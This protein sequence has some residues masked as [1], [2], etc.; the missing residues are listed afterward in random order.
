MLKLLQNSCDESSPE[1]VVMG[2]LSNPIGLLQKR[3]QPVS[4]LEEAGTMPARV[5]TRCAASLVSKFPPLSLVRR[6]QG[7]RSAKR[8]SQSL[9]QSIE[10]VHQARTSFFESLTD[11]S[12]IAWI[13]PDA[14]APFVPFAALQRSPHAVDC[15]GKT[16]P[17]KMMAAAVHTYFALE[18]IGRMGS[19]AVEI[20]RLRAGARDVELSTPLS[21]PWQP[22]PRFGSPHPHVP[23]TPSL[24][25]PEGGAV[26]AATGQGGSSG[27]PPAASSPIPQPQFPES[28]EASRQAEAESRAHIAVDTA[29]S[30]TKTPGRT[31]NAQALL[32]VMRT[33]REVTQTLTVQG[34]DL[35]EVKDLRRLAARGEAAVL[36]SH[37]ETAAR[38][39][40]IVAV[41]GTLYPSVE[42]PPPRSIDVHD[43]NVRSSLTSEFDAM[44][45]RAEQHQA[46]DIL[47]A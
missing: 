39:D 4:E 9:K 47:D 1:L 28:T 5:V 33:M 26:G 11:G 40:W 37:M 41:L 24:E 15:S 38:V 42:Q 27:A 13:G 20:E 35:A 25:T 14:A 31:E 34:E 12:S 45:S 3:G 21:E 46:Q 43:P 19:P 7:H 17:L 23:C 6:L 22:Q 16:L 36:M 8:M 44:A 2:P 10:Q 32:A 30:A 29:R 18:S